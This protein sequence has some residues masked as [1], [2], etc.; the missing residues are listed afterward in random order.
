MSSPVDVNINDSKQVKWIKREI[1]LVLVV[2][3][4]VGYME[5]E[6]KVVR[7]KSLI[8]VVL[9]CV[10]VV[11]GNKNFIF[12]F[13]YERFKDIGTGQLTIVSGEEK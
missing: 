2:K 13:K 3:A 12:Q 5:Q 4:K 11:V 10:Q 7:S 1:E 8:S 9:G 6:E